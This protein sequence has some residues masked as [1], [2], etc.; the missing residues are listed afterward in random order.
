MDFLWR[1]NSRHVLAVCAASL[2]AAGLGGACAAQDEGGAVTRAGYHGAYLDWSGKKPPGPE[3]APA[4]PAQDDAADLTEARYAPAPDYDPGRY[5]PQPSRSAP[6]ADASESRYASSPSAPEPRPA[7]APSPAAYSAPAPYAPPRAPAEAAPAPRPAPAAVQ[8]S[9]PAPASPVNIFDEPANPPAAAE[10][11]E[12]TVGGRF[13]SVD[14]EYGLKPDPIPEPTAG[15][16]VLIAPDP[17]AGADDHGDGDDDQNGV[18]GGDKPSA[19][20]DKGAGGQSR[21]N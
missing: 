4:S 9:A 10:H 18:A 5:A 21:D 17:A 1:I 16:T 3:T 2:L 19:H 15:H 13:Y 11:A 14:R 8:A 7:P 12:S 6:A 20:G